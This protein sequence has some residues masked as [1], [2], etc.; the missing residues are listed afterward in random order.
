MLEI[1][2]GSRELEV[3]VEGDERRDVV[4]AIGK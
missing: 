4:V 3:E 2:S 1:F